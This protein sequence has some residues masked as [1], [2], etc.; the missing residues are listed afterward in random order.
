[1]SRQKYSLAVVGLASAGKI[2]GCEP[3]TFL[4]ISDKA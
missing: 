2:V 3:T 1:L 4:V